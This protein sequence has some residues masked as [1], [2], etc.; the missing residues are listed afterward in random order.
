ML[1]SQAQQ[2]QPKAWPSGSQLVVAPQIRT[3]MTSTSS[4]MANLGSAAAALGLN[5]PEAT[6]QLQAQQAATLAAQQQQQQQQQAIS[7][8][9]QAAVNNNEWSVRVEKGTPQ[10]GVPMEAWPP[11]TLRITHVAMGQD[12]KPP[13]TRALLMRRPGMSGFP[14]G[15]TWEDKIRSVFHIAQPLTATHYDAAAHPARTV[16]FGDRGC[17]ALIYP[18]GECAI[19]RGQGAD[20]CDGCKNTRCVWYCTDASLPPL[21]LKLLQCYLSIAILCRPHRCA[22]DGRARAQCARNPA[23]SPAAM[24]ARDGVARG[25]R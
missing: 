8:H 3:T 17:F 14:P 9:H 4:S 18:T 7:P 20:C 22:R 24:R 6:Q 12:T 10:A 23:Q 5:L 13:V 21:H 1:T 11:V 19:C 25:R 2:Q 16:T 15:Q